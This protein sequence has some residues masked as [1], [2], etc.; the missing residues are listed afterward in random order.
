[1]KD[2]T[3]ASDIASLRQ[4]CDNND[5]VA[6]LGIDDDNSNSIMVGAVDNC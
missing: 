1:M 2:K 6:V 4:K 5:L 3:L